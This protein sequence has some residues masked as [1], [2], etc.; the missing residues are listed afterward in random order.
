M[1]DVV[2]LPYFAPAESLPAPLPS[3]AEILAA[4]DVLKEC[5]VVRIEP[6]FIVKLGSRTDA[7]EG[8]NMILTARHTSV[9]VPAVYAIYTDPELDATKGFQETFIVMENIPGQSLEN[10][11]PTLSPNERTDVTT[12]L[13]GYFRQLRDIPAPGYYGSIDNS[14]LRDVLF[15]M[16]EPELPSAAVCGPFASESE[17]NAGLLLHHEHRTRENGIVVTKTDFYRRKIHTVLRHHPPVF[18]HADLQRKNVMVRRLAE[19]RPRWPAHGGKSSS[20]ELASDEGMKDQLSSSSAD[21]NDSSDSN[22]L[23]DKP[24]IRQRPS[25]L[26]RLLG[27]FFRK[28]SKAS[29]QNDD[30][31]D[32]A[33]RLKGVPKLNSN[34]KSSPATPAPEWQRKALLSRTESQSETTQ[35]DVTLIDFESSGWYP[36]Y[37]EYCNAAAAFRFNDD[38][39]EHVDR[40]LQPP[41]AEYLALSQ[42]RFEIWGF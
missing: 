42:L 33:R 35:F 9:R 22:D 20:G 28:S 14:H 21:R 27:L 4:T 19:P 34:P 3:K 18:T 8:Q 41:M 15:T 10:V 5:R 25:L 38:W 31:A 30:E 6:H 32:T 26:R 37:W 39:D 24:P 29:A 13:Q 16:N 23:P 40:I 11:W 36:S 1:P 12:T 7:I 2:S 17:L